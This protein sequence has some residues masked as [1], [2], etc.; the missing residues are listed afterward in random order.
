MTPEE[1]KQINAIQE[2]VA[3]DDQD[4][5]WQGLESFIAFESKSI[6]EAIM[7]TGKYWLEVCRRYKQAGSAGITKEQAREL[8]MQF[9][10][11]HHWLG[12]GHSGAEKTIDTYLSTPPSIV[13]DNA[14]EREGAYH[15][16]NEKVIADLHLLRVYF[17]E[18]D[19][20]PFEHWAHGFIVSLIAKLRLNYPFPSAPTSKAESVSEGD[21]PP[22]VA[23]DAMVTEEEKRSFQILD[24]MN[25]ADIK[26]GTSLV[27]VSNHFLSGDKVKGGAKIC[28]GV[29][30]DMLFDLMN[31]KR[32][33]FV[34]LADKEQFSKYKI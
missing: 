22:P 19:V 4:L 27:A 12:F 34:V 5:S 9:A 20:T 26:N 6:K 7:I 25:C 17:G 21:K 24:E 2:Q 15:E 14:G 30:E 8:L 13:A 18:H 10:M 33:A 29:T 16:I 1:T 11:K 28:F 32:M 23:N 3:K 31:N